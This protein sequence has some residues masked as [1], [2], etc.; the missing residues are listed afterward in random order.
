M[1]RRETHF[2]LGLSLRDAVET[3]V[4]KR[5]DS[6]SSEARSRWGE[7]YGLAFHSELQEE[8]LRPTEKVLVGREGC[9]DRA[10]GMGYL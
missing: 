10:L 2:C 4:W 7:K 9:G 6:R 1:S 8:P 5:A 3:S